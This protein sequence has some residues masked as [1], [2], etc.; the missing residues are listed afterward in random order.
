MYK[1]I[2]CDLDGT[3]FDDDRNLTDKNIKAISKAK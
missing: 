2:F 1:Y 3:L